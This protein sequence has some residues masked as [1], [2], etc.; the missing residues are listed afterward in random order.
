MFHTNTINPNM[1]HTNTLNPNMFHTNAVNPNMFCTSMFHTNTFH[2][3]TF[4]PNTFEPNTFHTNN[5]HVWPKH[6]G[7]KDTANQAI[8]FEG[9]YITDYTKDKFFFISIG[10]NWKSSKFPLKSFIESI[11]LISWTQE[12]Q[13]ENMIKITFIC[14]PGSQN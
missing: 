1:F 8:K 7:A 4:D 14:V 10:A 12:V 3:N 13:E 9:K 11:F 2:I 6:G 5:H